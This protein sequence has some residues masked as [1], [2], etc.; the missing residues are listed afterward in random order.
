M[1]DEENLIAPLLY[2]LERDG[3]LVETATDGGEALEAARARPP[4]MII[5]DIMGSV[6]LVCFGSDCS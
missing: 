4:S 2:N 5:L 6:A 3:Y 1:E